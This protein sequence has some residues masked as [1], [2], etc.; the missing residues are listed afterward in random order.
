M[1]QG[2]SLIELILALCIIAILATIALP[3]LRTPKQDALL[4]KLKADYT[5]I[6]SAIAMIKNE[7][8][9]KNRTSRL[10]VLDEAGLNVEKEA[11]FY[12]TKAQISSCVNNNCCVYSVLSSPLYSSFKGWI[13]TGFNRY[14]FHLGAK[15]FVDFSF[16][17]DEGVFECKNSPLCKEL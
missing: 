14:R 3:Y 11:L 12:C 17:A 8:F 2:F 4:L 6:Q 1:K 10:S 15:N 13:K 9:I 16:N 7:N 5:M